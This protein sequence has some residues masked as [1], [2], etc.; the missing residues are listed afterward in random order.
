[1]RFRKKIEMEQIKKYWYFIVAL[2][3]F[4]MFYKPVFCFLLLGIL[5][6]F[7]AIN[8]LTFFDYINKNGIK[9]NGKILSYEKDEDG[10]KTPII[11]FKTLDGNII[12]KKPHYYAS[13][14]L[15][16]VITYQHNINKNVEIVYS[17]KKPEMF[18]L[19]TEK[20]FNYGSVILIMIISLIFSGIAIGKILGVLNI[21][22]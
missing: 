19:E 13:T 5:L 21:E 7:F 22:M 10:H 18:I 11:E 1:L 15:S 2:F 6:M 4:F 8:S 3:I 9:T 12:I 16:I 14:D 17:P 20:K